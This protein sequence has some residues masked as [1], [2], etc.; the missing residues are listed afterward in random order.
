MSQTQY[1]VVH[2]QVGA[3]T[4]GAVVTAA[5]FP[6]EANLDRLI[7]LGALVPATAEE[8]TAWEQA[9]ALPAGTAAKAAALDAASPTLATGQPGGAPLPGRGL[10]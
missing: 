6:A 7:G 1:R 5:D 3:H 2:N 9:N 10:K 4:E 8:A